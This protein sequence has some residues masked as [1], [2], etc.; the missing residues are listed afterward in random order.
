MVMAALVVFRGS[1]TVGITSL[2]VMMT[3]RMVGLGLAPSHDTTEGRPSAL[4]LLRQ[5]YRHHG[6][7]RGRESTRKQQHCC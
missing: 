1:G 5:H 2:S 4:L 6:R 7:R 3:R